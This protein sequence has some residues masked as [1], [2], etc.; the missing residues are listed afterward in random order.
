MRIVQVFFYCFLFFIPAVLGGFF[1]IINH[2]AID[3]SLLVHYDPG[4]PSIL[5]DDEGKE[6]GRFQLDKREPISIE[7]MPLCLRNAFIAAEDWQFYSHSGISWKGILRSLLVNCIYGKKMQGA[8]TITQQLVKLLFFDSKKT[9]KRKI[10]EQLYAILAEQQCTKEQILE[11]YLNNVYFGCG[12]YGVQA[13]SQRFWSKHAQDLTLDECAVLAAIIRCPGQ[14]NPLFYP[15]STQRRRN[16]IL[17]S[18]KNLHLISP[19]EYEMAIN[20]S[21]IIMPDDNPII[22]PHAK[23]LIR[24]QLEQ[25]MGYDLLY[26]G[27]LVIQTTLKRSLQELAEKV[28]TANITGFKKN[29]MPEIDGALLSIDRKTGHV[30]AMVGGYNFNQSKFNRA[31]QAKRQIG[32]VIKPLIYAAAIREGA[33]FADTEI[34]EP[35]S[36]G[37]H[38]SF[39]EPNNY[40]NRFDGSMTLAYALIRSNNIVAIKTLLKTGI[41]HTIDLVKACG[42]QEKLHPYP[43][44]ALGCVDATLKEVVGMF[45]IF[46]NDGVYVEPTL[47]QWIKDP[48]GTKIWKK[49]IRKEHVLADTIA[50]KVTKVLE[51]SF[52]RLLLVTGKENIGCEAICKTGTTND[53]R[54][55]LF[56]GSTPELT[57][58]I[59]IGCDD[60]RAMEDIFPIKTA[61]PIWYELHRKI[62]APVKKFFYHSDLLKISINPYN[63]KNMPP[64]SGET[65]E[66]FC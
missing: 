62:A 15:L 1:Y 39:W 46:V 19:E 21:I 3:F 28:F 17:K 38:N 52:K 23:E 13:A 34:D 54:T 36:I 57:T 22:A 44:L 14:Y 40:D 27:G 41:H 7:N 4:K 26:R 50:Q 61:F 35:I 33:S 18:M 60:N 48:W 9:F 53:C 32:S 42:I 16:I 51:Q 65:I 59:Y 29:I 45:N 5:L 6:W 66:I 11:T 31:W 10:K 37:Q 49:G 58:A 25:E 8:S 47:I 30:K 24:M 64:S 55:C 63:G 2:H 56:A 43:S 20:K 12:I